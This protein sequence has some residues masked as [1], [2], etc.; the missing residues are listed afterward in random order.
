[1]TEAQF[2]TLVKF[3]STGDFKSDLR[4]DEGTITHLFLHIVP[5]HVINNI[6]RNGTI[7]GMEETRK[8]VEMW[9]DSGKMPKKVVKLWRSRGVEVYPNVEGEKPK[10]HREHKNCYEFTR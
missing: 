4:S 6:T 3:Y 8:L 5:R 10:F 9:I 2:P 7:A 1:M